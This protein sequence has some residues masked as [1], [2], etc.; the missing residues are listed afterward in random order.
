MNPFNDLINYSNW[1]EETKK[2]VMIYGIRIGWTA[3]LIIYTIV[4]FSSMNKAPSTT[5][6]TKNIA[7]YLKNCLN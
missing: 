1:D 3:F 2:T 6:L 5:I 7:I 4:F